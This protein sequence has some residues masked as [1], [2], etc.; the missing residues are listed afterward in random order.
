MYSQLYRLIFYINLS[1][2]A[3]NLF[4]FGSLYGLLMLFCSTKALGQEAKP[5]IIMILA[6]DLGYGEL[7]SYGSKDCRTP[8]LDI[9]RVRQSFEP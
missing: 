6:D 4:L 2:G 9:C 5:N 3:G 7:S 8:T 1:R